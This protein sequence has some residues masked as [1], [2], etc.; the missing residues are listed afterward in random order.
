MLRV[1][2]QSVTFVTQ[3]AHRVL[4]P[5]TPPMASETDSGRLSAAHAADT[6]I[7]VR[8]G[9]TKGYEL[10]SLLTPPAYVAFVLMRKGRAHFA[11]NRFL[12]AAW[13]GGA[14]GT[15]PTRDF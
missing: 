4:R 9:M 15:Q 3:P 12:R 1:R 13:A 14:I 10:F 6:E 2:A 7:L 8:R 5:A 11:V